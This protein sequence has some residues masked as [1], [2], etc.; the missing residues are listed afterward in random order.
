MNI[1][2][3]CFFFKTVFF[4]ISFSF[5]MASVF[6]FADHLKCTDFIFVDFSYVSPFQVLCSYMLCLLIF[7][8]VCFLLKYL[9]MIPTTVSLPTP[10]RVTWALNCRR[11]SMEWP[12]DS[13]V[14]LELGQLVSLVWDSY[15]K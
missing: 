15:N 10:G 1:L 6:F 12:K 5:L 9:T 4:I 14:S 7:M 3:I 2:F 11:V 13:G 8:V